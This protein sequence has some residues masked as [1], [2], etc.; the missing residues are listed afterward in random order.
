MT[1]PRP[2][3]DPLRKQIV[4]AEA[5]LTELEAA[6]AASKQHLAKLRSELA[7]LERPT[8]EL[9]VPDPVR[10]P[11]S[12]NEK[13]A[14]FRSLF[15]GRFDV[16]PKLW[17][18]P[19]TK[20]Q[21]YA[22]ACANEWVGGVC[23]KPR[24]KCGECPNQAFLE[25]NDRVIV[26][27]LQGRHVAGVYPLLQDE[28]CWFLA[29]D[30]DKGHW[31]EDVAVYVATCRRFGLTPAVE[32]SRSGNGA[33]VWFFFSATVPASSARQM[34]SYLITETTPSR[35]RL[36]MSSYDR[37]FPNQDTMPRGGFGNLIALPFQLEARERGNTVFVDDAWEPFPEQWAHLAALPRIDPA[38]VDELA[39]EASGRGMV[40]GVRA[41]D[42][43]DEKPEL[44]WLRLP[45]RRHPKP[46]IDGPLPSE[47]HAVLA[48][49]LFVDRAGLPPALVNA[50]NRLAAFENPQFHEKQAMRLSTALTP[51]VISCAEDL[52]EHIGLPRGC[53]SAL[54]DLLDRHGIHLIVEDQR[55]EGLRLALEFHGEL[56]ALQ[57]RAGQAL[58][59]HD[60]GVFVAPP[61]TGKTVVGAHLI[62]NRD[63]NALVIV[64]RTQLVDQWRAQLSL[65]LDLKPSDVGQIGGGRRRVTGVVDVAMIQSLVR[66]GD[67]DDVVG[68]YGHVIVDECHHV[69]AVSFERVM[70]EVRA[71]YV[72]GLTA[73]PRR[74][75]GHHPILEFRIGPIRFSVDPR[76][77]AARRPFEHRLIV[78][79]TGFQLVTSS[80]APR[81]QEIYGQLAVDEARNQMIGDDIIRA[82]E[83]GRS[84][85]LLTE[86]RDHLDDI[87]ERLRRVARNVV[88]LRG[89]MSSKRRQGAAEALKSIP[90]T[91]ERVLLATG[92]F[93]GEGFDDARLDTLFL[94]MPVSWRGTLVQYAGR[95]HRTHHGKTDVRIFDY[96]DHDVPMLARM[97]QKRL[98]GYRAM[99]YELAGPP[100]VT[101]PVRERVIEYDEEALRTLDA[102]PF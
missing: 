90:D 61:G 32:R 98:R 87:A 93:A 24:V 5:R 12:K 73:T 22:P 10:P 83:D 76:N 66:S 78:R 50:I 41:A 21:G 53:A 55:I 92:R 86:R 80:Q 64:H 33:H 56:T 17:R 18:N 31:Q 44:P 89:G 28:R 101:A 3:P 42:T 7:A 37:L 46:L 99:G 38:R 97:F 100:M 74:R 6:Q 51:R 81:I 85:I 96:V 62:A 88:V 1:L 39:R 40:L 9:L 95:L 4:E 102:D 54:E 27:H 29:V 45:T 30:F 91:E 13:V 49:Q 2:N 43:A 65:F 16:F 77:Q 52:P 15:A 11:L 35:P 82:L 68:T 47:V 72:T 70:R 20:K 26:D 57:Q 36:P 69:P 14:L 23:E 34:G 71:R 63:R 67:V 84:P 19:K 58:L 94:A 8:G 79:E 60:T 59:G 25:L 75:D 48:Q